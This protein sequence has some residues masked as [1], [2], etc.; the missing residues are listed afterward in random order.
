MKRHVISAAVA[1]L[2][3][4]ALVAGQVKDVNQVLA[5][6]RAALGGDKIATV[7]TITA[8]GRTLR[9]AG[10]RTIENE[11]E[12]AMELPDK[13]VMR[14]VLAAM[15]NMSVYR[16]TGFN[17]GQV[18][19]EID[20][21]P[22]L[23]GGNIMIRMGGPLGA[24][25]DPAT[26]TPEQKAEADRLR[27]VANKREFARLTL[28]MFASS[29]AAF[30]LEF[31]Y[32][33]QAE[34]AE[35]KADVINVKGE[36]DFYVILFV[37]AQTHMPLM[38]SWMDKEP[39]VI[40]SNSGGPGGPGGASGGAGETRIMT[41]SGG[42]GAVGGMAGGGASFTA[43]MPAGGA[44]GGQKMSKEELEKMQKDF[45]ERRK[46]AEARRR[47]VEFRVYYGEYKSV[48]GVKLPFRI[49]RSIDGKTT[50][51]MVFDTIKLNPKIDAKKFEVSK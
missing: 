49:A 27:L 33:G 50:E 13:Y 2:A 5:D 37:D 46:E 4:E 28:G 12:M 20:R 26:I 22:N 21:P 30:P 29:P 38:V 14:S 8:V 39:I 44:G 45:E 41:F 15:G 7:K 43:A 16:N 17:G 35:G 9:T 32:A 36:G 31:T 40:T 6:T 51:E 48:G 34:A 1:I 23:Q 10:D 19:E 47:T 25:M 3:I 18:I 24:A 11:F 42:G